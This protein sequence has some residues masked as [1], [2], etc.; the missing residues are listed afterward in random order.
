MS[1]TTTKKRTSTKAT[2]KSSLP[3]K[4][5]PNAFL[6]EIFDLVS[7]QRTKASK[8]NILREYDD[9]SLRT[10][11]IWNFDESVISLLPEG[12]VPYS[13]LKDQTSLG[14][15]LTD[16]VNSKISGSDE[17]V[18]FNGLSESASAGHTSL[19]REHSKLYNFVKGG[20]DG[21]KSMRRETM[22]IQILEGLHPLEAEL[23]ILVKDKKL[24]EKYKITKEIVAEAYP[25]IVWGGRS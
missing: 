17:R 3:E 11:F 15:T 1:T 14:G 21:L 25:D 9:P 16:K 22:F 20:N 24:S 18:T 4:L 6:F 23:L 19:R 5:Q 8:I 7:K 13:S 12:H 10:I 2:S